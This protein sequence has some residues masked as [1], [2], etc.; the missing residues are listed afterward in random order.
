[1]NNFVGQLLNFIILVSLITNSALSQDKKQSDLWLALGL[2]PLIG[3]IS[4]VMPQVGIT[5]IYRFLFISLPFFIGIILVMR[6]LKYSLN[7]IGFNLNNIL[8]Q[9]LLSFEGMLLGPIGFLILLPQAFTQSLSFP[10]VVPPILIL[11]FATG[12]TEEMAFR[13]VMQRAAQALGSWGWLYI[14]AVY[15]ILQIGH[16]SLLFVLLA[17]LISIYFGWIVK[18][19][20][21][22][23]GVILAHGLFNIGLYLILPHVYRG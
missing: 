17:L 2:V 3:I 8:I 7:D 10:V 19:T 14:A 9:I 11:L 5:Q 15:A 21:S 13:G 20:Q 12:F 4:Q 18:K 1:V 16:R 6:T 22:I 23:S